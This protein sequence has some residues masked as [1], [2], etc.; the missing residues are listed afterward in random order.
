LVSADDD[1][2]SA[3]QL[4]GKINNQIEFSQLADKFDID[5]DGLLSK[6]E[7][8][9]SNNSDLYIA[10]NRLDTNSDT[11]ISEQEFLAFIKNK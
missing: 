9:A 7:L 1:T 4:K 11:N 5:K 10:F 3:V 6:K 8:K 2:S